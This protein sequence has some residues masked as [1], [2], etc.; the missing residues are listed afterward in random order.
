VRQYVELGFMHNPDEITALLEI[1]PT[2][3]H[4]AGDER[5]PGKIWK[6]DFW[7]LRSGVDDS[8]IDAERH[9]AALFDK[10]GSRICTI[11]EFARRSE[12]VVSW[13]ILVFADEQVPNGVIPGELLG[14][15]YEIGA[16][17]NVSMYFD[18]RNL[19]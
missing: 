13:V 7:A 19:G 17:L 1:Q 9:F 16:D 14:K 3:A 2:E 5:I 12:P 6:H 18:R 8:E 11:R 10:L 15:I 4:K